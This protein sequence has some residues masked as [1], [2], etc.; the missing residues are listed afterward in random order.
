MTQDSRSSKFIPAFPAMLK[1]KCPRCRQGNMFKSFFSN[2][3]YEECGHCGLTFE[4]NPG[5]F[6]TAMYVTYVFNVAEIVTLG[7]A[8]FILSGGS[9]NPWL[10]VGIIIPG[11]LLLAPLNYRY[12]RIIQ[13]YWLDPTLKYR[14]DLSGNKNDQTP[15]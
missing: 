10:Y 5:Y 6:Y 2:T 11:I 7:I 1:G 14:P 13:M 3:M 15:A 4:R 9:D 12:S 8:T